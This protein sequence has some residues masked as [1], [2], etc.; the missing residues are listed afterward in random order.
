M[1]TV[2]TR[3]QEKN[4]LSEIDIAEAQTNHHSI[5]QRNGGHAENSLREGSRLER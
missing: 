1:Q 5:A 4:N 2:Q 3:Y